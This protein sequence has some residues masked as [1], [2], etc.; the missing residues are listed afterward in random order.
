MMQCVSSV[1]YAINFNGEKRGFIRPTRGLRQG[2]PL[3]PYLFL[4]CAEGFS[5]LLKQAVVQG[6]LTGVR[7]A[8]EAPRLSH[9][10]LADDSLIFCKATTMET[11]QLRRILE[12]TGK[13]RDN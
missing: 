2:D 9:L 13:L 11:G 8:Q 10:F 12:D 3:C 4:I 7:I 5:S 6:K 1:T